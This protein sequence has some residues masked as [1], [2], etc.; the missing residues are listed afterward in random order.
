MDNSSED[1]SLQSLLTRSTG[2]EHHKAHTDPKPCEVKPKNFLR[3][4]LWFY[5]DE[6]QEGGAKS[7]ASKSMLRAGWNKGHV[8][9]IVRGKFP[10]EITYEGSNGSIKINTLLNLDSY[11]V[12]GTAPIASTWALVPC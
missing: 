1:E 6:D 8:T 10:L 5:F 12:A 11:W 3:R 2:P 7:G 9:K 4:E